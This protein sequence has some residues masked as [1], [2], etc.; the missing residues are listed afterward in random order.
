MDVARQMAQRLPRFKEEELR[1]FGRGRYWKE[2]FRRGRPAEMQGVRL[3]L[4]AWI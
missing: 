4:G 1:A 3:R 2:D